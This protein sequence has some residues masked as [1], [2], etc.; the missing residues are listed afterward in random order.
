[1]DFVVAIQC[2][3]DKDDKGFI[4][5]ELAVYNMESHCMGLWHFLPPYG[6]FEQTVRQK[7]TNNW[8][9]NNLH[10]IPWEFGY[11]Q[12]GTVGSVLQ[13]VIPKNAYANIYCKGHEVKKFLEEKSGYTVTDV[14]NNA[15]YLKQSLCLN[16]P[17]IIPQEKCT[18][19]DGTCFHKQ[20]CLMKVL[21]IAQVLNTS[22]SIVC[23]DVC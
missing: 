23:E 18:V 8:V 7:V 12:Q 14:N 5:K 16:L 19:H 2:Y 11:S 22:D 1:M 13:S 9:E 20:C 10:G 15:E 21:K 17:T 4:L 3:K 6:K